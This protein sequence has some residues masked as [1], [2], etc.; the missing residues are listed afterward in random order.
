M[1]PNVNNLNEGNLVSSPDNLCTSSGGNEF[2]S[3]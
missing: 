3:V 2:D 1:T